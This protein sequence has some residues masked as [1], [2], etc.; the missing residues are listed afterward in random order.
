MVWS[1]VC[2]V[3]RLSLLRLPPRFR[4]G[5]TSEI[6]L[7]LSGFA[8]HEFPNLWLET[9]SW[10]LPETFSLSLTG[11]RLGPKQ[12]RRVND[13][14]ASL[15]IAE[16]STMT[17]I[18]RLLVNISSKVMCSYIHIQF[19]QWINWHTC[20]VITNC[21]AWQNTCT[22]KSGVVS[23]VWSSW[24]KCWGRQLNKNLFKDSK[25]QLNSPVL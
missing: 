17:E 1:I 11:I 12:A 20:N 2:F 15:S 22:S 3:L 9:F 13:S 25:W 7:T 21:W 18:R 5:L 6:V 24:F 16:Q 23:K 8:R 10:T 14:T 4:Q 19:E